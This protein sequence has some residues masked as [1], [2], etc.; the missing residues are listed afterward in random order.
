VERIQQ[1]GVAL[2]TFAA[3]Q[4]SDPACLQKLHEL[5]LAVLA[6]WPDP[7]PDPHPA[8]PPP[9]AEFRRLFDALVGAPECLLLTEAEERMI[10]SCGG[11]G[12]AVHP[13]YRGWGIATAME[14]RA[15]ERWW[16]EEQK[17]LF[18]ASAN[19]AMCA[20]YAKLGYQRVF[21]EVRLIRWLEGPKAARG[22]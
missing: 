4:T 2:T 22:Y 6:D 1:R 20:V 11:L 21:T 3:A 12:T 15:I 8:E 7:D 5:Y 19:P 17:N 10:G 18:G 16:G 14:A 9:F 13:G